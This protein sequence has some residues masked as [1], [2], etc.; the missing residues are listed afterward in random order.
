MSHKRKQERQRR[1]LRAASRSAEQVLNLEQRATEL[2]QELARVRAERTALEVDLAHERRRVEAARTAEADAENGR[3]LAL[4]EAATAHDA[5]ASVRRRND[6]L[7]GVVSE[8]EKRLSDA[9]A[10]VAALEAEGVEKL[11]RRLAAKTAELER[12]W[13]EVAAARADARAAR[14]V[15]EAQKVAA[16]RLEVQR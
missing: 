15:L 5:E 10:R 7:E 16:A 2:A 14:L 12:A 1:V 4:A 3:R 13:R 11:R 6:E 9:E 8:L